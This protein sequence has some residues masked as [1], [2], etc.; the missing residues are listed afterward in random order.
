MFMLHQWKGSRRD[1]NFSKDCPFPFTLEDSNSS[2]ANI[3]IF[4]IRLNLILFDIFGDSR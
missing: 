4:K 2:G 3:S 1:V